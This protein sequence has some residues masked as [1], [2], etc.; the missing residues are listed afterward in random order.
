MNVCI[1]DESV[2]CRVILLLCMFHVA[3]LSLPDK[4]LSTTVLSI[5]AQCGLLELSTR[6]LAC[7]GIGGHAERCRR[8]SHLAAP[9]GWRGYQV[10]FDDAAAG[11]LGPLRWISNKFC[12]QALAFWAVSRPSL[13]LLLL[14][15]SIVR[16]YVNLSVLIAV[17]LTLIICGQICLRFKRLLG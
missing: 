15:L 6:M 11:L 1:N 3:A 2:S 17:T 10:Q 7:S 9:G 5:N 8:G 16:A 13:A 4:V 14:L 12:K